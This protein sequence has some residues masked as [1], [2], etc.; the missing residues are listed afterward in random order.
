MK[1]I[2]MHL[3]NFQ[4]YEKLEISLKR[5]YSI[6]LSNPFILF[7]LFAYRSIIKTKLLIVITINHLLIIDEV[8]VLISIP[9]YN[10]ILH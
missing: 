7:F 4:G 1:Y 9:L 8:G 3:I 6:T 5:S 10:L 2:A